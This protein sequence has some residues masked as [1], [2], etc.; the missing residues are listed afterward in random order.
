[1]SLDVALLDRHPLVVARGLT[2]LLENIR[3]RFFLVFLRSVVLVD[4]GFNLV[5]SFSRY[6]R[7]FLDGLSRKG[8][9][10]SI[11]RLVELP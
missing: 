4:L 7:D 6:L 3:L 5:N 11:G 10:G 1:M 9:H 8:H 2:V